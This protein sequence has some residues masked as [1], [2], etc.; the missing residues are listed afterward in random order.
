MTVGLSVC[1]GRGLGEGGYLE[2]GLLAWLQP[3]RQQG[4]SPCDTCRMTLLFFFL[5]LVAA[6]NPGVP[7]LQVPTPIFAF[8]IIRLPPVCL[9]PYVAIF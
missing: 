2:T 6:G 4:Q 8:I 9:C 1:K 3:R 7:G 5:A